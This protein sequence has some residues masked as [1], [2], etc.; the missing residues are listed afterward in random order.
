MM[1]VIKKHYLL[2]KEL[3]KHFYYNKMLSLS[4]LSKL[5]NKSIPLITSTVNSLIEDGYVLEHGLAPSTGGRRGLTFLLNKELRRYVVAVAIDQMV[6]QV[7]IYDLFNNVK[8][9]PEKKEIVLVDEPLL[10][11]KLTEFLNGY[12]ARSGLQPEEIL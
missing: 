7:V 9:P 10:L 2:K 1:T 4:E 12:I 8:V 5:T 6:T 11:D 3:I